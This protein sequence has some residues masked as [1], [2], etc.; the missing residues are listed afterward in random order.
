MDELEEFPTTKTKQA[1]TKI[2]A[3]GARALR[4][5]LKTNTTLLSLNLPREQKKARKIN[6]FQE[7]TTT[8]TKQADNKIGAEGARALSEAL[9]TNTTLQTLNLWGEQED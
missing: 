2:G 1:D 3:E 8:K 9:K 7:L 6:E 4:D 5:A